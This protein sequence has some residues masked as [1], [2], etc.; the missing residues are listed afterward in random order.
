MLVR[1]WESTGIL[2]SGQ[3]VLHQ[4]VPAQIQFDKRCS[5]EYGNQYNGIHSHV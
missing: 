1:R 3:K 4:L 2:C 5:V